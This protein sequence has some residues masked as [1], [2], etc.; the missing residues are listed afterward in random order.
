MKNKEKEKFELEAKVKAVKR[1]EDQKR[2]VKIKAFKEAAKKEERKE[3][4]RRERLVKKAKEDG[5]KSLRKWFCNGS[6]SEEDTTDTDEEGWTSIDRKEK[7]KLKA[8]KTQRKKKDLETDVVDKASHILGLGPISQSQSLQ[9]H[10][11]NTH[12]IETAKREAIK[13]FLSFYLK[14][15]EEELA[16]IRINDTQITASGDIVYA[17]FDSLEDIKNIH[18]TAAECQNNTVNLRNYIP[19]QYYAKYMFISKIM[20][21]MRE[22]DPQLKTKMRFDN[23]GIAVLIKTKG[24]DEPFKPIPLEDLPHF[25]SIPQFDHKIQWN[26]KSDRINRRTVSSSPNKGVPPS[27]APSNEKNVHLLSRQSSSH[28]QSQSPKKTKLDADSR[29]SDTDL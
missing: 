28:S 25:A 6:E 13:D 10:I 5:L 7:N 16:E 12:G 20:R 26:K 29:L 11:R 3:K 14:F 1:L 15:D 27:M 24:S 19:P 18:I 21:D 17:A 23:K 9:F 2:E 22:K 4:R 8:K